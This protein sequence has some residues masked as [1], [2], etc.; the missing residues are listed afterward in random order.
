MDHCGISTETQL[1]GGVILIAKPRSNDEAFKLRDASSYDPVVTEFD[2]WTTRFTA[3]LAEKLVT[4]AGLLAG[5]KVLDIGTGTGVVALAAARRVQPRGC[6]LGVDLSAAMLETAAAKASQ[7]ALADVTFEKMDAENLK[8]RDTSFDAVLSMYALLH[9]PHPDV[10]LSEMFRVLRPGGTL[11]L[12]VGSGPPLT[13]AGIIHRASRVPDLL[14]RTRGRLL[15]APQFLD[16]MV[17]KYLPL[18][19]EP[20]ETSLASENRNRTR[21]VPRLVRA[22]GFDSVRTCW[23]GRADCIE[24]PADFW[25]LQRTYSSISR[26][27]LASAQPEILELLKRDFFE[28]C[29]RVQM[30]GGRLMRHHA[31]FYVIARRPVT[32]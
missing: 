27:R 5:S 24:S 30:R 14:Q 23:E 22:A 15:L 16:S 12:A 7:L 18:S 25:D 1:L 31:A 29:R 9:F 13:P 28:Q 19:V 21:S 2:R 17:D 20:E 6:V 32:K 3:P 11:V 10:A 8:V 26:K 4:L